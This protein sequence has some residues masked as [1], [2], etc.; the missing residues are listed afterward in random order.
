MVTTPGYLKS[1]L[2]NR[3]VKRRWD[4]SNLKCVV[5][6]EADEL[7]LQENNLTCFAMFRQEV[8]KLKVTPQYILFSA[9]FSDTTKQIA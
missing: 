3:D 8:D 1:I 4:L 9:T 2:N 5:F 7:L 6:D